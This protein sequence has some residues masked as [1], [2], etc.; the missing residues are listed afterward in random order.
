[1][2]FAELVEGPV[3]S[4]GIAINSAASAPTIGP[5]GEGWKIRII[6]S[7]DQTG[8]HEVYKLVFQ[9][10]GLFNSVTHGPKA[11]RELMVISGVLKVAPADN[12]A[13]VTVGDTTRYYANCT[14]AIH[15]SGG[16]AIAFLII[17]SSWTQSVGKFLCGLQ[18]LKRNMPQRQTQL[19]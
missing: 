1:M 19:L 2:S 10:S 4:R 5:L 7:P 9:P 14:H 6:N 11:K 15:A 8:Q 13:L 3:Q 18:R 16:P 12:T 17:E